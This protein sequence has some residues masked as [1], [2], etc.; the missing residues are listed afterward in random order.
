MQQPT[1]GAVVP[2]TNQAGGVSCY[3]CGKVGHFAR[4]CWSAGNGRP[5]PVQAPVQIDEETAEM[6]E[7]FRKKI[8]KQK[9]EEER[10]EKEVVDRMRREE[11]ARKEADRLR[12]ADE[13]EARLEARLLRLLAQH[14]KASSSYHVPV[15]KSPTTKA[16]MLKEITSY[17][18]KSE[19]E[20]EEVKHEDGRLIDA[21][22]RRKG[23][24]RKENQNMRVSRAP[25][26]GTR[27]ALIVVEEVPDELRT[28]PSC[29]GAGEILD[30]AL[31]LH[32]KLSA[33]KVPELRD[34]CNS[35]GIEWTKRETAIGELVKC[36]M[37]LAYENEATRLSRLAE[38]GEKRV[39]GK[40]DDGKGKEKAESSK[41]GEKSNKTLDDK[42]VLVDD[43]VE[44]KDSKEVGEKV[45]QTKSNQE[46]VEEK[47]KGKGM[48]EV[49][50]QAQGLM[51]LVKNLDPEALG[52]NFVA[53]DPLPQDQPSPPEQEVIPENSEGKAVNTE[54]D[55]SQEN[56]DPLDGEKI[57]LLFKAIDASRK[58]DS[59]TGKRKKKSAPKGQE[60]QNNGKR[61]FGSSLSKPGPAKKSRL[62]D[63]S[64]LYRRYFD[65]D[66]ATEE[67]ETVPQT[68]VGKRS[69]RNRASNVDFSFQRRCR[70]WIVRTRRARW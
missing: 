30:F 42:D 58:G 60:G 21:I 55:P 66:Q 61:G 17:L 34:L 38:R 67:E 46:V 65:A 48:E 40:E 24:K 45:E 59:K 51:E 70:R 37:K 6:K 50:G 3:L 5:P 23:K 64:S 56:G 54:G 39:E 8:R 49:D 44:E 10:R 25:K 18:E 68:A 11:E 62:E 7:Y 1:Y 20:S 31:D 69:L 16:R 13:R 53:T 2:P 19:D 27:P 4:N 41:S 26:I 14:T 32:R 47:E 35:E 63:G 28:P 29:R 33:K 12:E 52:F 9:L 22:E 15:K 43:K 57:D 36:R